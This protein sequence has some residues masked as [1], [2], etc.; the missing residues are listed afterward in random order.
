ML[1]TV[2]ALAG[3]GGCA[4]GLQNGYFSKGD[5]RYRV[6]APPP[7]W[8]QLRLAGNDLAY[9]SDDK[10]HSIA[11][12]ATC[13]NHEDPPLE[14]LTQHLLLGFTDRENKKTE[15]LKLDGR[16]ALRSWYTAKLDGIPVDLDLVVMKKDGC[17]HDFVYLS[18]VDR[19]DQQ[20]S[21]FEKVLQEFHAE[22]RP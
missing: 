7:G 9:V 11:L 19:G 8:H 16:E 21:V 4:R 6:A 18:P 13:E 14:V 2:A 10:A 17:V 12:N 1:L 20:R 22:H 3:G 5:L 15:A